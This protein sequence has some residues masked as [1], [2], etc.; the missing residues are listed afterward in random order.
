[1]PF[2]L[3][4]DSIKKCKDTGG[5]MSSSLHMAFDETALRVLISRELLLEPISRVKADKHPL[6]ESEDLVYFS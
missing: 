6:R 2:V 4:N 3:E 5:T 1:M